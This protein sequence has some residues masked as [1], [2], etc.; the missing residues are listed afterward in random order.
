MDHFSNALLC[1]GLFF[2]VV[3]FVSLILAAIESR[4]TGRNCS[5]ILIPF[6]G[7]IALTGW[8]LITGRSSWFIPLIWI[9]DLGTIL[10]LWVLPRLITEAWRISRWTLLMRFDA[11]HRQSMA[12]LTLHRHGYYFLRRTWVRTTSF[13]PLS[14]GETGR[15]LESHDRIVL[16]SDDGTERRQLHHQL[17]CIWIM[18]DSNDKKI[19][20]V[21]SLDRW[22]FQQR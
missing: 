3:S 13:G 2:P 19:R 17:D 4:R 5:A 14:A 10:F 20:G 8:I 22:R 12:T 11:T 9:T 21:E 16:T 15:Y 6:V 1:F 7:P 18:N